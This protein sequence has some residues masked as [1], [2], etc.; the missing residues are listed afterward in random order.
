M[1]HQL[2][3]AASIGRVLCMACLTIVI[4]RSVAADEI[5]E[6]CGL[7]PPPNSA[8]FNDYNKER[9][10]IRAQ[11]G[12]EPGCDQY[13]ATLPPPFPLETLE[14]VRS[15]LAFQPITWRPL[16]QPSVYWEPAR[17]L[18]TTNVARWHCAAILRQATVSFSSSS[19]SILRSPAVCTSCT[20]SVKLNASR[21]STRCSQLNSQGAARCSQFLAGRRIGVT[22][23]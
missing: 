13:I 12:Y 2:I 15:K 3:G 23:N 19:R 4:G 9:E 17:T 14:T 5:A 16:L 1:S 8:S 21:A 11:L 10:H 22:L 6:R 20:P 18:S 7:G